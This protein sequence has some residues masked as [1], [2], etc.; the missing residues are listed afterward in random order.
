MCWLNSLLLSLRSHVDQ[1]RR[2]SAGARHRR[3]I[4]V[5]EFI[6]VVYLGLKLCLPRFG[7]QI[8]RA[9]GATVIC[10]SSSDAKLEKAKQLGATHLVNY[11]K[12]P[13]WDEEVLRLT[14][15]LGVDFIIEVRDQ[16][17]TG[18]IRFHADR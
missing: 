6:A 10:T 5:I 15:G 3:C 7:I 4:F 8:A 1:G 18:S 9:A 16:N 11:I 14:D 12:T 13:H 2:H 17:F